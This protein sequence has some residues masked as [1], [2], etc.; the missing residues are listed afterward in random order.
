MTEYEHPTTEDEVEQAFHASLMGFDDDPRALPNSLM[1]QAYRH[2]C[3]LGLDNL[4][5][6]MFTCVALNRKVLLL[7]ERFAYL[8][9]LAM[10]LPI[11]TN[12]NDEKQNDLAPPG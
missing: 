11:K 1:K 7:N 8:I 3:A 9:D 2:A 4:H 5:A 6:V 10:P 12:N